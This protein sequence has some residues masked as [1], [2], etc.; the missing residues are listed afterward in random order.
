MRVVGLLRNP[1]DRL[2]AAFFSFGQYHMHY[3]DS[4]SGVRAYM[5]E[6]AGAFRACATRHGDCACALK[7]EALAAAYQDLYYHCDQL[8][9]GLYAPFVEEWLRAVGGRANAHFELSED[10]FASRRAVLARVAT[11]SGL[12]ATD[13]ELDAMAAKPHRPPQKRSPGGQVRSWD[14]SAALRAEVESFYRPYNEQL[15][16]L[17]GEPRY[18]QWPLYVPND[19]STAAAAAHSRRR[20]LRHL[21]E[22]GDSAA[23]RQLRTW[24]ASLVATQSPAR[25]ASA[26][27]RA[28]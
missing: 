10:F 28:Y 11:F 12:R 20:R 24:N 14:M 7:F 16:R 25:R 5:A 19:A 26:G 3:G 15:A 27:R 21:R 9:K 17:L 23:G 18:A 1:V 22:D 6:Q 4:E 13:A 2:W 8:L